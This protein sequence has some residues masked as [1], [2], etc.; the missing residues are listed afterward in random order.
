MDI[1]IAEPD[2]IGRDKLGDGRPQV[3]LG[4]GVLIPLPSDCGRSASHRSRAQLSAP[5]LCIWNIRSQKA[6]SV[7]SRTSEQPLT[8][9]DLRCRGFTVLAGFRLTSQF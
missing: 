3:A 2:V 6:R 7:S 9:S 8:V 4:L 5:V 1:A